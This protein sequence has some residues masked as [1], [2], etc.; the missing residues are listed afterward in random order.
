M[1]EILSLFFLGIAVSI[2][3]F[4]VAFTYGLKKLT[5]AP[6]VIA[7]IGICSGLAFGIA[8]AAGQVLAL[9]ITETLMTVIGAILLISLGC[10]SLLTFDKG[11]EKQSLTKSYQLNLKRMDIVIKIFHKPAFADLDQSGDIT[12]LEVVWLALA[13][14]I[15]AA[16]AGLGASLVGIHVIAIGLISLMTIIFLALGL[17]IGSQFAQK[18]LHRGVRYIPGLLLILIGFSRLFI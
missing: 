16:V 11:K 18:E 14:S 17:F 1:V 5:L 12:G 2:D 4:M 15:D 13:L 10:Y 6:I 9:L 8:M 3:S 7:L